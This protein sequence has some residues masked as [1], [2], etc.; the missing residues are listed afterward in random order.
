[1][2]CC[3]G[4]DLRVGKKKQLGPR[5]TTPFP[6]ED[7]RTIVVSNDNRRHQKERGTDLKGWGQ[8]ECSRW[9]SLV[10]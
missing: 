5:M 6:K 8:Q 3:P 9:T 1:M 10:V 4:F 7:G 2:N